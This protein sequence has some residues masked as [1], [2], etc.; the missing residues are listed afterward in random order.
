M[1]AAAAC[2][3]G[4]SQNTGAQTLVQTT[5]MRVCIYTYG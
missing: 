1:Y 4:E 2:V 5:V 3:F